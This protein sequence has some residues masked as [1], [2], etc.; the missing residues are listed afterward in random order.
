MRWLNNLIGFKD[1]ARYAIGIDVSH[2]NGT[3]NWKKVKN[4]SQNI[5]FAY[6][7]A[8]QGIDFVDPKFVANVQ[9][10]KAAGI[11]WGA[12][13]YATWNN[14]DILSD[15]RFE[16]ANFLSKIKMLGTPDMPLVLDAESNDKPPLSPEE[17]LSF[18]QTFLSEVTKAGYEVMLY[19]FPSWLNSY[20]P[21]NHGLGKYKLWLADYNGPLNPVNGWSSAYMHQ[22]TDSG[23][24]SGIDG[25]VDMNKL[26]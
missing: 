22:Y 19:S 23:K 15:A 4:D 5:Q 14:H 12:Y 1:D 3:I 20:L 2:N 17:L 6:I 9:A 7:K 11:K 8:T 25:N 18:I 21:K 10:C 13:H 16:A 24:V 26:L